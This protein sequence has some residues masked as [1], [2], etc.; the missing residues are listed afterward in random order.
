[1]VNWA[2]PTATAYFRQST[3]YVF[4]DFVYCPLHCSLSTN[5]CPLLCVLSLFIVKYPFSESTTFCPWWVVH[6][7]VFSKLCLSIVHFPLYSSYCQWFTAHCPLSIV[8][9]PLFTTYCSLSAVLSAVHSPVITEL[10]IPLNIYCQLLTVYC[11][12]NFPCSLYCFVHF[13]LS[14]VRF[15]YCTSRDNW[16]F[17]I[18]HCSLHSVH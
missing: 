12:R 18:V 4:T 8:Y 17:F 14:M 13:L 3:V 7:A 15:I 1:M 5:N 9:C 6:S 11:S 2:F 16:A 10:S